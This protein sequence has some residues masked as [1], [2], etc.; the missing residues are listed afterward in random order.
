MQDFIANNVD[1]YNPEMADLYKSILPVTETGKCDPSKTNTC[2][3]YSYSL[4]REFPEGQIYVA[5]KG[6]QSFHSLYVYEE[7]GKRYF[8]EPNM[9]NGQAIE[10][11]VGNVVENGKYKITVNAVEDN[12]NFSITIKSDMGSIYNFD[13]RPYVKTINDIEDSILSGFEAFKNYL[14]SGIQIYLSDRT[15]Y[16]IKAIIFDPIK[17]QLKICYPN[18]FANHLKPPLPR[19]LTY[20]LKT[21]PIED[22]KNY[23]KLISEKFGLEIYSNLVEFAKNYVDFQEQMQG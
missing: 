17:R 23:E 3:D 13:C 22:L 2:F 5:T 19:R 4:Y 11:L 8:L 9:I 6:E 18:Q 16:K 10:I 7:E 21:L 12:A 1:N 20:I 15:S 14:S